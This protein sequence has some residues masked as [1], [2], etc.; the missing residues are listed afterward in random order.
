MVGIQ[1]MVERVQAGNVLV[2]LED[3]R[4]VAIQG[5]RQTGKSTLAHQ[6]AGKINAVYVTLDDA[7]IREVAAANPYDFV[8]QATGRLLIIDEIQRVPDLILAIKEV[9]D[10]NPRP[11]QYLITGSSDLSGIATIQESLA[12]RMEVFELCGFSQSEI[13]ETEP[14]FLDIL[15]AEGSELARID[16]AGELSRSDYLKLAMLGGY[17]EVLQRADKTRRDSWFDNYLKL[18]LGQEASSV[19][20]LR[21]LNIL[22][23]LLSYLATI[24]GRQLVMTNVARDIAE[25]RTSLEAY[26][27]LMRSMFLISVLPAWSSNLT[28]RAIKH[29]KIMFLDSG[30]L[31][32]LLRAGETTPDDTLSPLAGALFETFVFSEIYKMSTY[33]SDYRLYYYRDTMKREIDLV[34]ESATGDLLFIE[35]KASSTAQSSD[36]KVMREIGRMHESKVKQLIVLYT[37]TKVLRFGEKQVALPADTLWRM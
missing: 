13:H 3:T 2:A 36:F 15:F 21:R 9:V 12:G 22:P 17:P 33:S 10:T 18:L 8:R 19:S 6:V 16:R 32:R 37:G 30:L 27:A 11:G 5:A 25:P 29:P 20:T 7:S 23:K 26:L 4:I 35:V 14:R 34:I 24:S 1:E 31:A 28:T